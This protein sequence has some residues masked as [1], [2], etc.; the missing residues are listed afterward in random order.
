[1]PE[2]WPIIT[3]RLGPTFRIFSLRIDV[4]RAPHTG[5]EHEFCII[6]SP[7]WVN[8]IP[9]TTDHKVVMVKQFRHG[10]KAVTLEIPGGM[11]EFGDSPQE[12][13]ERELLEETGYQA[14][15]LIL[16]GE[17]H[18]NP[19]FLTNRCYTFLANNVQ[20]I[21]EKKKL[22]ETED[23]EVELVSLKKIPE[24]IREGRISNSLVVTA[25]WWF[26][27]DKIDFSKFI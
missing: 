5:K 2:P 12:S 27:S 24:L 11:I 7:D 22:D 13:A 25:F 8:I 19:A 4:A 21:N 16:L 26:F 18:P 10:I 20:K 1:M 14:E 3:S 6:D 23:I 17:V 9:I 15:E